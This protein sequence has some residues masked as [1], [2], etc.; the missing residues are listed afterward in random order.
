MAC[1][2]RSCKV[3]DAAPGS[4]QLKRVLQ[5][6]ATSLGKDGLLTGEA[7]AGRAESW[8]SPK[9]C[10]ALGIALP[11]STEEVAT[12]LRICNNEAQPVV[13]YGGGTGLVGGATAGPHEIVVSLERMRTI[14]EVDTMM[15]IATVQ[16]GATLES[17]QQAAAKAD[18][19][20]PLDLGARGTA[21][22]GGNLAT[23]AGGNR[24]IRFGMMRD[25]VLGLEA[26]LADGTVLT[27][28]N[29]LIKNNAGY[30]LKQLFMGTEGT[31]GVVTRA[32]L[33]L[34]ERW[35]SQIV[36]LVATDEFRNLP[37]LL[38]SLDKRLGGTLS[39]FEVM[40]P[41][42]Y[43]LVTTPPARNQP[44]L[45]RGHSF[46]CLVEALGGDEETDRQ[47]FEGALATLLDDG[48]I[49]DATI[50]SS[51]LQIAQLWAL[52]DDVEQ[53][54]RIGPL[55][56]F[57]VGLPILAM[58]AYVAQVRSALVCMHESAVCVAWGHMGD[59]NLHL[60]IT[61]HDASDKARV[62][63]ERIVYDPIA[64][65]GG[66]VSAEHG[67]GAEKLDYLSSCRSP[68]EIS[69]MRQLKHSLDPKGILNPGKV[70]G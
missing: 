8:S 30:D 16:A 45:R 5:A 28:M 21:T 60:W 26:V 27:N 61:V 38:K 37:L 68:A 39:A 46:Y 57:D 3:N 47:R 62:R 43:E 70:I 33:R 31:L 65:I 11:R 44:P 51:S 6:L 14:E 29:R 22:I 55:F 67:I 50:A 15:R 56:M 4:D 25:M 13:P 42:F 54:L 52:R 2:N 69:L 12:I 9:N 63:V 18:L 58:E 49:V 36:A 48:T 10:R 17:V 53:I 41:E 40:W 35:N 34:R 20:F 23:N 64:A 24:V 19:Y 1:A 66:T 32:V 7:V 59:S